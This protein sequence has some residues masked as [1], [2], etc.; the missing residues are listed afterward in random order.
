MSKFFIGL[1]YLISI[2]LG[3][4]GTL[5]H[6]WTIIIAY[7]VSG[8]LAAIVTFFLIGLSEF[9]WAFQAW[10]TSGFDSSFIQWIIVFLALGIVRFIFIIFSG[11]FDRDK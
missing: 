5:F 11:I 1:T 6:I 3:I 2:L 8:I 10:K 7:N 4:G 9:Y